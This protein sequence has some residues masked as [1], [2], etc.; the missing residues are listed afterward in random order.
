MQRTSA[1]SIA[2]VLGAMSSPAGADDA[3]T[4]VNVPACK[5]YKTTA[6]KEVCGYENLE[7]WKRVLEADAELTHV[8]NQLKNEKALVDAVSKQRDLLISQVAKYMDSQLALTTHADKLTQDMIA[9]DKKYQDERVKPRW[10]SPVAW[11]IAAVSTSILAGFVISSA[12]D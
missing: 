4:P 1:L 8:R 11:T 9:L 2:F 12:L 5:M 3:Y 10:G 7:D 6:G